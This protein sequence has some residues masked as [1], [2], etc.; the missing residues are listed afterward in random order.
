MRS[1]RELTCFGTAFLLLLASAGIPTR[2]RAQPQEGTPL[3][4]TADVGFRVLSWNVSRENFLRS[5]DQYRAMLKLADADILLLDE[6]TGG[7]RSAEIAAVLPTADHES[8]GVWNIV[9]G[10]GGGYQRAAVISRHPVEPVV[11]AWSLESQGLAA[12]AGPS[13]LKNVFHV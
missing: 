12:T 4:R 1:Q 2:L 9:I 11:V 10:A 3:P 7:R 5:A 13:L 8:G 6:V